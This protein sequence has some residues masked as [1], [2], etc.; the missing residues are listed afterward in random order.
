MSPRRKHKRRK[1]R[2]APS[3]DMPDTPTPAAHSDDKGRHATPILGAKLQIPKAVIGQHE[4]AQPEN[5][6]RE[7]WKL[8]LEVLTLA[9]VTAYTSLAGVQACELRQTRMAA[10][11]PWVTIKTAQLLDDPVSNHKPR[12][13]IQFQNSGHTPALDT[14]FVVRSGVDRPLEGNDPFPANF[15]NDTVPPIQ[16]DPSR[17][18][19]GPNTIQTSHPTVDLTGYENRIPK[20]PSREQVIYVYG[21]V[22]YLDIFGRPHRTTFCAQTGYAPLLGPT[23][24]LEP[25][26]KCNTAD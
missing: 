17:S 4:T 5:K 8:M 23:V 7:R 11:R 9:V 22:T 21:A 24:F 16:G 19:M 3:I 20:L 18:V 12:L 2:Q 6:R 1:S 10:E 14:V 13:E 15:P 26:P 25:C